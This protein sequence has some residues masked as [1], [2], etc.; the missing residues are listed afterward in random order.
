M[1]GWIWNQEI[2]IGESSGGQK[3]FKKKKGQVFNI[4]SLFRVEVSI[5]LNFTSASSQETQY[6]LFDGPLQT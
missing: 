5:F 4:L 6:V 1:F 2:G 3:N